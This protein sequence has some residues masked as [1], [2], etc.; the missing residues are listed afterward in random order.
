MGIGESVPMLDSVERVTG[1]VDYM[2]NLHLPNM[3]F[4]KIVRSQAPHAKLLKVDTT[5]ALQV[6]GVVAVLTG[7]DLGSN[8]FYGVMIKDQGVVAV[9]R[10]RYVGEPIAAI[11]AETLE[12]A[13]EAAL[14]VDIEYEES[15]SVFDAKEAIQPGAPS[16]HEKFPNNIFKLA[17]LR[18]G[19]MEAA[20]AEADEIFEDTFI[21]PVAQQASLEPHVA[22]AQWD[23]E[24]LTIWTASQ[25][26]FMV[27]KVLSE[28][29]GI[30]PE[31]V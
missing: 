20:F 6:P 8:A 4:G 28:T 9:D 19:D 22:A 17:K 25:A 1:A 16:L 12:A 31:S 7:K 11:A 14:L 21:S 30:A 5:N 24:H 13:E 3:L 18:H 29:F 26:P 15:P 10:V 2:F 27:R 23:G